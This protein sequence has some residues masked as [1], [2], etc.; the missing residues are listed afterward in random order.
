MSEDIK[1][2]CC[3]FLF[4]LFFTRPSLSWTAQRQPRIVMFTRG[5][6]VGTTIDRICEVQTLDNSLNIGLRA[7]YLRAI[8]A[9]GASD[10]R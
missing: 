8:T 2:W 9:A 7:G 1:F 3:T 5:S 10:R 4:I 6:A